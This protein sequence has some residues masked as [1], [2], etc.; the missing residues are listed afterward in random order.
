VPIIR[1]LNGKI[2]FYIGIA[3]LDVFII[4]IIFLVDFSP[5]KSLIFIGIVLFKLYFLSYISAGFM[6]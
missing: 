2:S 3:V 6:A 5:T 4:P 1:V